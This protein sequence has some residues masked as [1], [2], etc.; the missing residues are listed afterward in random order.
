MFLNRNAE[1]AVGLICACLP[2]LNVLISRSSQDFESYLRRRKYH[3]NSNGSDNGVQL[4]DIR[5]ISKG[6]RM[7]AAE[8]SEIQ[9]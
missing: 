6:S 1:G 4:R 2:A 3:N 7:A 8:Y 9:D 5:R